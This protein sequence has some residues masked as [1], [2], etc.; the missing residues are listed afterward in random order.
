MPKIYF[1]KSEREKKEVRSARLSA[2]YQYSAFKVED[3]R[4]D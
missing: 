2:E 4:D 1:F 3:L